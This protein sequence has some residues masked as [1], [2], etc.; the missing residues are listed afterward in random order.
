MIKLGDGIN[1]YYMWYQLHKSY[2]S[3]AIPA[4]GCAKQHPGQSAAAPTSQP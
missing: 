2:I 3:T 4:T 1:F